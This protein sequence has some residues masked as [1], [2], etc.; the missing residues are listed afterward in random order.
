MSV[1]FLPEMVGAKGFEPSTPRSRT[2]C[3]TRLSH[4]PTRREPSFYLNPTTSLPESSPIRQALEKRQRI[5]GGQ[6]RLQ[7]RHRHIAVADRLIIGAIVRRPVVLP[8]LNPVVWAARRID[9]RGNHSNVIALR[10]NGRTEVP[11]DG[12]TARSYS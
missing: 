11:S 12:P 10:L 7:W 9:A 4:A 1:S 6:V 2:E 3:S 5:V 8:F